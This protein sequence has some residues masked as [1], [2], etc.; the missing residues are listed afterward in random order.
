VAYRAWG[1]GLSIQ[2][3]RNHEAEIFVDVL[4]ASNL[5]YVLTT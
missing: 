4:G 2:R 3:R 5:T 1:S